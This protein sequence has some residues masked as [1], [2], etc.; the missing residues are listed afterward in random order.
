MLFG[1]FIHHQP[2]VLSRQP[3]QLS[4]DAAFAQA[5]AL[6]V[7]YFGEAA[8]G[9]TKLEP[10]DSIFPVEN[11]PQQQNLREKGYLPLDRSAC[12]RPRSSLLASSPVSKSR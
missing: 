12:G 9:D 2:D 5:T 11:Q 1:R 4:L 10:P 3:D 8:F 6:G 7:Q